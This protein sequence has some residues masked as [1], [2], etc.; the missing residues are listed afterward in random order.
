MLLP[1]EFQKDFDAMP[2]ALQQLLLAELAAGNRILELGHS[3]PAPP[4]GAYFLLANPVSTR[5]RSSGDGLVFYARNSSLSSILFWSPRCPGR[6]SP[7][8][9]PSA[10]RSSGRRSPQRPPSPARQ[11]PALLRQRKLRHCYNPAHSNA[12]GGA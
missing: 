1:S 12:S 8:W 7:T 4:A 2:V 10:P 9:T 5:P 11:P 6:R 3:F